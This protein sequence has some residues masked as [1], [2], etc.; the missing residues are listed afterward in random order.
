[1]IPV[2]ASVPVSV[3]DTAAL[4]GRGDDIVRLRLPPTGRPG[5][6]RGWTR[7]VP[8]QNALVILATAGFAQDSRAGVTIG[9]TRRHKSCQR[10]IW[11]NPLL[12]FSSFDPKSGGIRA[13]LS[14]VDD[15][16]PVHSLD[17]LTAGAAVVQCTGRR[18]P[19]LTSWRAAT[20]FRA[21]FR[22]GFREGS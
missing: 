22:A 9:T 16:R 7:R 10:P 13:S 8:G 4:L 19:G 3:D 12:R 11:L 17:S 18:D 21:G 2:S 6:R 15:F 5:G 20:G 1:M 14:L